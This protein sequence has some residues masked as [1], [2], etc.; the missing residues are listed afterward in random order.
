MGAEQFFGRLTPC[1]T[2]MGNRRALASPQ[3]KKG[4]FSRSWQ[5]SKTVSFQINLCHSSVSLGIR[6]SLI[7][8]D[9]NITKGEIASP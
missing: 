2:L 6:G 4:E 5:R 8:V 9:I 1:N 7:P 3:S